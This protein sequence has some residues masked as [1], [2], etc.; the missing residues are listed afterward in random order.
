MYVYRNSA[1]E[2]AAA[3]ALAPAEVTV[4][5]TLMAQYESELK[6]VIHLYSDAIR[7]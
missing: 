5:P 1:L 4:D 7:R 3:P 2:F 6:Q